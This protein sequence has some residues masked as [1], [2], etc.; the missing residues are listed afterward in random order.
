MCKKRLNKIVYFLIIVMG[1]SCALPNV[2]PESLLK[3]LPNW[4]AQNQIVMGLDLRGG[5]HLL[6]SVKTDELL[7]LKNQSLAKGIARHL[8]QSNLRTPSAD[9]TKEGVMYTNIRAAEEAHLREAVKV[10]LSELTPGLAAYSIKKTNNSM[11]VLMTKHYTESLIDDAVERSVDVVRSRLD[12]TGVVEPSITRQGKHNILIQLPGVDD[13]GRILKLLGTTALMS[14]HWVSDYLSP[15]KT[16]LRLKDKQNERLFHLEESV[17]MEGRHVRD[18]RLGFNQ[19]TNNPVV[20][21]QLDSAGKRQFSD[22]TKRYIGRHLAIVLDN[23]VLTAPVIREPITGGRGEI[24]GEFTAA[25][26]S[27][28][29]LLL[30]SGSLPAPLEVLEERSVGAELGKD[31]IDKGI[32]TGVIGALLVVGFMIVIYGRWGLI[33]SLGLLI[34]MGLIFGVLSALGATLTLPGIAGIILGIG[35]AVDAI[36]LIN[37]RIK[38]EIQKGKRAFAAFD[39]GFRLAFNTILDSNITTLIAISFLF[40][41][42][43]GAIRGFAITMAVGLFTSMFTT[44]SF[45]RTTMSWRAKKRGRQP[46]KISTL[47]LLKNIDRLSNSIH[48][49]QFRW[50]SMSI[51][52]ALAIGSLALASASSLNY[53]IDFRGGSLIEAYLPHTKIEDLRKTLDDSTTQKILIQQVGDKSHFIIR[54]PAEKET[55]IEDER[56]SV[57]KLSEKIK[58]EISEIS[59]NARI[60]RTETVGPKI[61]ASFIETGLSAILL[62]GVGM[63]IYLG[64]R[65]EKHFAAAAI[66]TVA[67]DLVVTLGFFALTRIEFNLT[68][69]TALLALIGYSINDKVVV[70]DRI[71]ESLRKAPQSPLSQLFNESIKATLSR[72]A[73]TSLTTMLAI[74]P[75]TISGGKAVE[76]FALPML[77]GVIIGTISSILV[78]ASILL[79]LSERRAKRGLAQLDSQTEDLRRLEESP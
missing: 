25:E 29:A 53:G 67:L 79:W 36:I 49:M 42:G 38:E 51:A 45:M 71:R 4:Y 32:T 24:S 9:T 18:A 30:R 28:L 11:R 19:V 47:P 64:F 22:M 33:A 44:L 43:E 39:A 23:K 78:A 72:T 61:S 70:F 14:F 21:F 7:L 52:L 46:L 12:E 3:N 55:S 74:L 75:M 56:P 59:E 13:P 48:F 26:A 35:M 15:S 60:L 54:L 77:F 37:E 2:L 65:F 1:L 34:N 76:S 20:N 58:L 17:A 31:S 10:V 69:V 5:S 62:A 57:T 16:S 40:L 68:A 41:F 66:V 73:L 8:S 6:M 63:L 50:L 27:D